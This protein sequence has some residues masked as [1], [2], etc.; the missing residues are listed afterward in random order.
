MKKIIAAL[1]IG[2]LASPLFALEISGNKFL[3]DQQILDALAMREGE[4]FAGE[5]RATAALVRTLYQSQGFLDC[6][7]F[8]SSQVIRVD[9]GRRFLFG[10][11][12][13][14]GLVTLPDP[15]VQMN[16]AYKKGDPYRTADIFRTQSQLYQTN[17]FEEVS[18]RSSTSTVGVADI[19]IVFRQ[20]PMRWV[21]GGV[22]YGSEERQRFSLSLSDNN[23]GRRGYKME[24]SALLSAIWLEYKAEFVNRYLFGRRVEQRTVV[25]WRSEDRD[26][27]SFE[28]ILGDAGLGRALRWRTNGTVNLRLQRTN[29]FDVDPAIAN[30]TPDISDQRS[31]VF[32]VNRD[33]TNDLFFPT[34]G[35]RSFLTLERAGGFLGGNI[36]YHRANVESR[37]YR[38]P[39]RPVTIAVAGRAGII[40]PYGLSED[41][42]IF[43]RFFL[44]GGN[45]VRGY[46]E[47]GVGPRDP[48]DNPTGGEFLLRANFELRFPIVWRFNGAVFFDGGQVGQ[49]S[50]DVRPSEWRTSAGAG[51][52]FTTPV[53]PFRLDWGYKLNPP[54]GDRDRWRFHLSLG[55]SF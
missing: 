32:G 6:R 47:R 27:Y 18:I 50:G 10:D 31:V 15:V 29:T 23:F 52:R 40:Q 54:P 8:V 46:S 19:L 9:E 4:A 24:L 55:E 35:L 38:T 34:D 36:Y 39:F 49:N 21:K 33:A 13:F 37:F 3:S 1:F 7:V 45:S 42:P 28:R 25:S 17:L 44:G 22:G 11:T 16:L 53:G 14:E 51:L 12:R 5:D 20:K 26:G 43:E 30:V 48:D 41:V 2:L